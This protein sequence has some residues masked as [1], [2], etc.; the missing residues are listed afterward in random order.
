MIISINAE[1]PLKK[2]SIA[3]YFKKIFYLDIL[4][5]QGGIHSNN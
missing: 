5:I 4:I 1:N 2:I 3:S